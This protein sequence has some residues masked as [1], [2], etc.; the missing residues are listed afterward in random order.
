MTTVTTVEDFLQRKFGNSIRE[1]TN[2]QQVPRH[3]VVINRG[4]SPSTIKSTRPLGHVKNH[5]ESNTNFVRRQQAPRAPTATSNH[6]Q[7]RAEYQ[8]EYH[9]GYGLQRSRSSPAIGPPSDPAPSR[10]VDSY[11][12]Y[13]DY[14]RTG[15]ES[16]PDC[17]SGS[18]YLTESYDAPP[19]APSVTTSRGRNSQPRGLGIESVQLENGGRDEVQNGEKASDG[20]LAD[21][22][23]PKRK[24][25]RS[26]MKRMFGPG[27]FL[28]NSGALNSPADPQY[29]KPKTG[30]GMMTKIF[31][32][33]IDN[34]VSWQ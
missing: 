3:P 28:G 14:E 6:R 10:A 1:A 31:K 22:F 24:R 32:A 18:T 21:P 2:L 12:A 29:V 17:Y 23:P 9:H 19:S 8:Q 34:I 13:N 5:S 11:A 30:G 15:Q 25:S 7:E 16:D 33:T 26:P 4:I 27:G 20:I